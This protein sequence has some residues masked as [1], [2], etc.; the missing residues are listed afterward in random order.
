MKVVAVRNFWLILIFAVSIAEAVYDEE[1]GCLRFLETRDS[2]YLPKE[3]S[4]DPARQPQIEV[5][6]SQ[7]P[8]KLEYLGG[9]KWRAIFD[10]SNLV[11]EPKEFAPSKDGWQTRLHYGDWTK[12][13]HFNDYSADYSVGI[14]Q[15]NR[16]IVVYDNSG[17]II[18]GKEPNLD[19]YKGTPTAQLSFKDSSPWEKNT[20][21]PELT[22]KNTGYVP[23]QN[24]HALIYLRFPANKTPNIPMDSWYTPE[25]APNLKHLGSD[26]WA[27][28]VH[29]N[30]HILYGADSVVEGNIGVHLTDWSE[31]EKV[32]CGLALK[33]SSGTIIYGHEPNVKE[34]LEYKPQSLEPVFAIFYRGRFPWQ[35]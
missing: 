13:D 16:K 15:E 34:C 22:I 10:G 11:I 7:I 29:F 14:P 18:W 24:Y 9:D 2:S 19:E 17:N 8:A 3:L 5:D 26:V 12:Y 31:F 1:I 6:Y 32:V 28:D 35:E 25:S 20:F 30:K 21:K 33:D 23:L 4:I 27:L